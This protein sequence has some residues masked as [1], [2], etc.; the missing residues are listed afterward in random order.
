MTS[1][2]KDR[3]KLI[4]QGIVGG[5]IWDYTDTG[6]LADIV[7]VA[8]FFS[9]AKHMGM[10]AGDF[11]YIRANDGGGTRV[12]RGAAMQSVQDTGTTQGTVG[13]SVLIGDTS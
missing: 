10:A 13:L 11:V 9:D 7:E 6:A 8:G 12:V 5:K 1:Y 2:S 3:L 4:G